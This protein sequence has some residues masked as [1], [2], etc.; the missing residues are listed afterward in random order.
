MIRA[1]SGSSE[2]SREEADA[3]DQD[4]LECP[5]SDDLIQVRPDSAEV[6]A[7]LVVDLKR[8]CFCSKRRL[9]I[10]RRMILSR[11]SRIV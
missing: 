10:V 8:L 5:S 4:V 1:F 3:D 2:M 7:H 11:S 6:L 9:W